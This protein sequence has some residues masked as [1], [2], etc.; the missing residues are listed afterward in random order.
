MESLGINV[1]A[2]V[3]CG[4]VSSAFEFPVAAPVMAARFA[5]ETTADFV[6]LIRDAWQKTI[7]GYIETG[8]WLVEAK[9]KLEHGE[10]L[11]MIEKGL[12][13]AT[14]TAQRLMVIA[15]DR[16]I[17]NAA[18]GQLLPPSWRTAYE[19]TK[20]T[21]AQ[22]ERRLGDGTIHPEMMRQDLVAAAKQERR[23]ACAA[24]EF[25]G[26]TVESLQ[27]LAAADFRAGVI[28]ADPPWKFVTR[29]ERGEG[30]S[31]NQHYRTE[32]LDLIR[33]LP[34]EQLA[35]DDCVLFMWVV[36]WCPAQA[37]EVVEAWG[38]RHK[39]TAFSWAKQNPSGEGWHM[40]QG[41][42]TRANPETCWLCT[43]GNPKRLYDDVRQLIVSPVMEHSR[44]P[45]AI[46]DRIERLA[47]GPF[48]ELYARHERPGWVSWGDQVPFKFPTSPDRD[49]IAIGA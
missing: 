15:Q 46:Y 44:K 17:L 30:R 31:A 39:T 1:A 7:W 27:A 19:L 29:S 34:V 33:Q 37:L 26:G 20:L 22:F 12:P 5:P 41:Y 40:G 35:A 45:D 21:D 6:G 25:A 9:A 8:R 23:A 2:P 16:R 43:R 24:R 47:E 13:F 49:V 14:R 18:Q 48:L 36:D 38:F 4:I 10:F 32:A 28:Y 42:W 3:P 11:A